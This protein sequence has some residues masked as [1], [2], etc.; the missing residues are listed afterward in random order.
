M[1]RHAIYTL[2]YTPLN[3]S[4]YSCYILR[5][6]KSFVIIIIMI[7]PNPSNFKFFS[8]QLSFILLFTNRIL[9]FFNIYFVYLY[10]VVVFIL[11]KLMNLRLA[12]CVFQNVI[13]VSFTWFYFFFFYCVITSSIWYLIHFIYRYS[14]D[15][16]VV[17]IVVDIVATLFK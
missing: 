5:S 7:E 9:E 12:T 10:V 13:C 8:I 17:A 3:S 6:F 2:L 4:D 15:Y 16:C 11:V 14:F 1:V